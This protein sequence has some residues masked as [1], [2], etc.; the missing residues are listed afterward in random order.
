MPVAATMQ[1]YSNVLTARIFSNS[2]NFETEGDIRQES[3]NQIDIS[4]KDLAIL[5]RASL[6]YLPPFQ[7]YES[8]KKLERSIPLRLLVHW[9]KFYVDSTLTPCTTLRNGIYQRSQNVYRGPDNIA[10]MN[11]TLIPRRR[12]DRQYFRTFA[13]ISNVVYIRMKI[14]KTQNHFPHSMEWCSTKFLRNNASNKTK[15]IRSHPHRP[16]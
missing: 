12:Y 15:C 4:L 11:T 7:S 8:L 3:S 6:A 9:A 1:T 14:L 5:S 2:R 10:Q 13:P 16:G